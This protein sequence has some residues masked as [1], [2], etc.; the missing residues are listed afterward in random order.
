M[1][2]KPS[3]PH[4]VYTFCKKPSHNEDVCCVKARSQP[5]KENVNF[6]SERIS[7]IGNRDVTT[8]VIQGIQIDVLND[9]GALNISSDVL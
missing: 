6:C 9:S 8:A 4:K 3:D 2:G 1:K 7:D 5:Q